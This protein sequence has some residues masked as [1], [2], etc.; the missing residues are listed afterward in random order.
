[1]TNFCTG[2]YRFWI[3]NKKIESDKKTYVQIYTKEF[4]SFNEND[5]SSTHRKFQLDR[6]DRL[7]KVVHYQT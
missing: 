7:V 1:M 2:Q 5:E 3:V 4:S 6:V